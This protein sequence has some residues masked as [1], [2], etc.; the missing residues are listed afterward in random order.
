MLD[1]QG[2]IEKHHGRGALIDTNL[3]VLLLVG[4]VNIDARRTNEGNI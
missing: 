4:A 3:L 1:A 2:L